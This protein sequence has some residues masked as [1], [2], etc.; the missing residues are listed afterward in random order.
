MSAA[1][2]AAG[3]LYASGRLRGKHKNEQEQDSA[4]IKSVQTGFGGCC[5]KC[6]QYDQECRC[7]TSGSKTNPKFYSV[8]TG[9]WSGK[10]PNISVKPKRKLVTPL[11]D[12]PQTDNCGFDRNSSINENRYVCTCGWTDP[13]PPKP[14]KVNL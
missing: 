3:Y 8:E 9:R 5:A 4:P 14:R 10:E 2:T 6:G 11:P 12:H 7:F 13:E 1:A